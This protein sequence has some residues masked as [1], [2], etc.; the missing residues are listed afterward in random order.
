[1]VP[2]VDRRLEHVLKLALLWAVSADPK[3]PQVTAVALRWARCVVD[4]AE[5]SISSVIQSAPLD[6]TS[7]R[8][9]DHCDR[10][11]HYIARRSSLTRGISF[12]EVQRGMDLRHDELRPLVEILIEQGRIEARD[13]KGRPVTAVRKGEAIT[14]RPSET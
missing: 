12:R 13:G 14:L 1:M 4:L 6:R 8:R 2:I 3:R 11:F 9:R 10:V 7:E 5:R